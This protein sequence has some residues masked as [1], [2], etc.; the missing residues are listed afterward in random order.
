MK[1][2]ILLLLAALSVSA[3]TRPAHR[4]PPAEKKNPAATV[5]A[6]ADPAEFCCRHPVRLFGDQTTVNL[7]PL[8]H[9]WTKNEDTTNQTAAAARPLSGWHRITG[10]KTGDLEYNWLVN[11]VIYTAP[12]LRTNAHIILKNPPTT[13]E[14][15]FADLQ[16][17]M[18][19]IDRQITGIQKSAQAHLKA[20]QKAEAR[21]QADKTHLRNRRTRI[22]E[23]NNAR[24]AAQENTAATDDLNDQKK[25]EH[26]R[27]Q[28]EKQ[29]ATIPAANGR[30]QI[31]WFALEIGRNKQGV[32]IYDLGV[33]NPN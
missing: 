30:Y 8:F 23:N 14:K 1:G 19:Q 18:A 12:N 22:N 24:Q 31:D 2:L 11:A 29:L 7:K 32:P 4:K 6:P 33:V 5:A 13:E 25:L 21:V 15:A 26:A 9:W 17:Q 28:A 27:E 16:N 20:A 10:V 3:Q